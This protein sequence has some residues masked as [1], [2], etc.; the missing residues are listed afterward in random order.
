MRERRGAYRVLVGK[1]ERKT[2]LGKTVRRTEDNID[3]D[4]Q[5]MGGDWHVLD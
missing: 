2:L 4:R 1:S 3:T 5:E